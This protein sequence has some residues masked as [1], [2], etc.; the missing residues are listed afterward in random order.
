MAWVIAL[1]A[2][3]WLCLAGAAPAEEAVPPGTTPAAAV[4]TP[5][6][7][8]PPEAAFPIAATLPHPASPA[9]ELTVEDC[10]RMGVAANLT[11]L[12]KGLE[13]DAKAFDIGIARR[14]FIP[15]VTAAV[16]ESRDATRTRVYGQGFSVTGVQGTKVALRNEYRDPEA[17]RSRDERTQVFALTQPLMKNFGRAVT[18]YAIDVARIDYEAGVERFRSD[19]N[20]FIYDLVTLCLDLS[21][22]RKNLA[23]QD[24]ACQRARQQFED[25][26]HDIGLGAIA[27]REIFLVEENLVGFEIKRQNARQEIAILELQLRQALNFDPSLDEGITAAD[28]LG[29]EGAALGE[30]AGAGPSPASFADIMAV[31]RQESP[32]LRLDR[33][34]EKRSLTALERERLQYH[35]RLDFALDWRWREGGTSRA[36]AYTVGLE[37][38]VPLSR[39]ADRAAVDQARLEREIRRLAVQDTETRLAYRLREVLLQIGHLRTVLAGKRRSVEL[40]RKTLDAENEKYRNGYSTL[41]DVVRFQRELESA[42]IDELSTRTNLEKACWRRFLLEGTLHRK[43]AITIDR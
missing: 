15:E 20:A 1:A 18:G 6:A 25:T 8:P 23:I 42:Q 4:A 29:S 17:G 39:S 13:R 24:A 36:N 31:A 3:G 7:P 2:F 14:V 32:D 11:L 41:A 33:L 21:F 10:V 30:A 38:E 43:F 37:Y 12:Q 27:E 34:L 19:L 28:A 9:V 40:S 26:R 22:A 35:P 5:A 16:T